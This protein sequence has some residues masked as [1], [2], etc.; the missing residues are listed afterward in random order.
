MDNIDNYNVGSIYSV[1]NVYYNK[2]T[3]RLLTKSWPLIY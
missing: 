2:A 3:I 1:Y